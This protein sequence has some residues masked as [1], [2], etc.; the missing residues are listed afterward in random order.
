MPEQVKVLAS[1]RAYEFSPD[2]LRLTMLSVQVVQQ[3]IQQLF[4]FQSVAIGSPIPT[5][6]EVPATYPPGVVFN[7][8]VWIHQEE[9]IVPIRFLHFE[10]NRIVIDIAG[11]TAAID[12]IAERLFHFLSGLRSPDGSPVVGGPERILNYSEITA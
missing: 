10:Q 9:H 2:S 4:G 11:P 8:G 12:E 7:L 5:F 3:Q 1:R 6:G